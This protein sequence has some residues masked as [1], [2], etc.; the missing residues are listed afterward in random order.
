MNP[1]QWGVARFMGPAWLYAFGLLG[2]FVAAS[3]F[4][5]PWQRP[6]PIALWFA[7]FLVGGLSLFFCFRKH[8]WWFGAF[9]AY[10]LFITP[11]CIDAPSIPIG[12]DV[13]N[14]T[15]GPV[16]VK[17]TSPDGRRVQ[18]RDLF[19]GAV[20]NFPYFAGSR[21]GTDAVGT[22]VEVVNLSTGQ[23]ASRLDPVQREKVA[24]GRLSIDIT[25]SWFSR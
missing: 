24:A 2:S 22:R 21:K 5:D 23:T 7:G 9:L 6:W 11:F 12:V 14:Q 15:Q 16:R 1:R 10:V 20:W 18:A 8:R 13:R 4:Y 19:P 3:C 25:Q 17:F